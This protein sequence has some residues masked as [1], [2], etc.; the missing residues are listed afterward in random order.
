MLIWCLELRSFNY[1]FAAAWLDEKLI[2]L[3]VRAAGSI[4]VL[5]VTCLILSLIKFFDAHVLPW[6]ILYAARKMSFH[7]GKK[8]CQVERSL[9]CHNF[10]VIVGGDAEKG[11]LICIIIVVS[12]LPHIL[13]PEHERWT[14]FYGR[15]RTNVCRSGRW[16]YC[17]TFGLPPDFTTSDGNL[18]K[19]VGHVHTSWQ[20]HSEKCSLN[21][22]W[23]E[24]RKWGGWMSLS[25]LCD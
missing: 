25:G 21:S 2:K 18:K 17:L 14:S 23:V 4:H 3:E 19:K 1:F 7:V 8:E 12:A 6:V 11:F 16:W 10:W 24:V 22:Q 13:S 9:R 15:R 5:Y 20:S